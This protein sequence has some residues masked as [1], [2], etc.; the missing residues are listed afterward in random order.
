MGTVSKIKGFTV[1][2]TL[3]MGTVVHLQCL[4]FLWYT[5]AQCYKYCCNQEM[6][7]AHVFFNKGS[8][9]TAGY[10]NLEQG[11]LESSS[12][13][14]EEEEEEEEEQEQEEMQQQDCK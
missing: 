10:V 8:A 13:K 6:L 4:W 3:A 12:M 11:R 5:H 7:I 1:P 2:I 9:E 14:E